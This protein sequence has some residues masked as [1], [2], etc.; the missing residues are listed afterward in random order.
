MPRTIIV[1]DVHGCAVELEQLL[2]EVKF[3]SCDNLVF[4]GDMIARGPD[5]LRVLDLYRKHHAVSVMGNHEERLLEYNKARLSGERGPRLGPAHYRLARELREADWE[6][7]EA[8]PYYLDFPEHGLRIVHAGLIP[9]VPMESQDPWVLMHI[10]SLDAEGRPSE[11]VGKE[12]WA[13]NYIREPHIVF[14]HNS[15]RKLQLWEAATGLD[16]ACVYGGELSALV[17]EAGQKIPTDIEA[18]RA[19]IVSVSARAL[20]Y[21]G[22][23]IHMDPKMKG[24]TIGN[25]SYPES[26]D[27]STTVVDN[28]TSN[29]KSNRRRGSARSRAN[30]GARRGPKKAG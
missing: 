28:T 25:R 22:L 21:R 30:H 17:L 19:L 10:R 20:Y 9:L 23:P 6:L 14:G 29:Q 26:Q 12:S 2:E 18:R 3:E 4:V 7:M 11:R 13:V 1:G 27:G 24:A 16:T 8:L 15:H 5:S